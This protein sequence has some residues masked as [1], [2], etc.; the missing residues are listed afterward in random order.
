MD[1]P[2]ILTI[3]IAGVLVAG[4]LAWLIYLQRKTAAEENRKVEGSKVMQLQAYERLALLVE[5]ITL[6]SV[7]GRVSS[8]DFNASNMR[9]AIIQT[10]NEEF[11]YNISQQIYVSVEAWN[12]IKTMK[13][14]NLLLVNQV[15]GMLPT[16]ASG[17]NLCRAI[18]EYQANDPKGNMNEVVSEIISYEAKKLL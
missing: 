4:F 15:A 2:N 7:I 13:E 16:D 6:S 10:I 5:R 11:T 1:A 9:F 14:Q 17:L 18:L 12:A 8:P 3:V